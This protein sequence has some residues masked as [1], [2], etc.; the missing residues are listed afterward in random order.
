MKSPDRL[1][2]VNECLGIASRTINNP[3]G[4]GK[5][6]SWFKYQG[7]SRIEAPILLIGAIA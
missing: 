7:A 1:V 4:K 6:Q 2:F 5:D 3:I